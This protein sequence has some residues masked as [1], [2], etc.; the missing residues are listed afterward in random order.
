MSPPLLSVCLITYNHAK[1]IREAIDG[2][3]MQKVNFSWELI[4]ADDFSTDG[5][6]EIVL[7]YKEKYPDFIKLILQEKNVGPAKNWMDL[8]TTPSS[9]YIAYFEGDDYWLSSDKLQKQVDILDARDDISFCFHNNLIIDEDDAEKVR[10]SNPKQSVVTTIEDIID[11][12]YVMTCSIM[13]RNAFIKELP[14]WYSNF[15]SGDY[16]L[17]LILAT[18][19]DVYYI[20]E[21]MGCYRI[22]KGG[23]SRTFKMYDSQYDLIDLLLNFNKY[24]NNQ[25]KYSIHKRISKIYKKLALYYKTDWNIPYFMSSI[26]KCVYYHA[27]QS[28]REVVNLGHYFI[29]YHKVPEN[30][31]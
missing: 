31:L 8:I 15:K 11:A 20:D 28:L 17:Q 14:P 10:I 21:I 24:T 13:F 22:H 25:Y 29:P 18:H 30:K 12:W 7:E 16:I 27:P 5:T 3:L 6:R 1:Y 2:V 4:I 9:K 26:A 23:I 19:G